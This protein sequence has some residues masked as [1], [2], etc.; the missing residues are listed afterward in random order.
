MQLQVSSETQFLVA[1]CAF[2]SRLLFLG[3][4][5]RRNRSFAKATT[6]DWRLVFYF[7]YERTYLIRAINRGP[8]DT[9]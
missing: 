3:R 4:N 9:N 8:V 6:S 1:L 2:R 7:T 5:A